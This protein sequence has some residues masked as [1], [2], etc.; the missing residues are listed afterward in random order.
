[1]EGWPARAVLHPDVMQLRFR[2]ATA[3]IRVPSSHSPFHSALNL[4]ST[5]ITHSNLTHRRDLALSAWNSV[6]MQ[7]PHEPLTA[8]EVVHDHH[9]YHPPASVVCAHQSG[10]RPRGKC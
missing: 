10:R 7:K 8:T 5:T 3:C 6:S 1:M 9:R 2:T 4:T